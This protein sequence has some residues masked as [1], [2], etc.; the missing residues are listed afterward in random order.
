M[1]SYF[2]Y[3]VASPE[4]QVAAGGKTTSDFEVHMYKDFD[5]TT[6][7]FARNAW[8]LIPTVEAHGLLPYF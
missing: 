4:G 2:Q 5:R 1:F 7:R 6:C 8:L 3:G